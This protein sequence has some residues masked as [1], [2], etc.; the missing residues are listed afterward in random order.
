[1][2]GAGARRP[3]RV[4]ASIALEIVVKRASGN[5]VSRA[6]ASEGA[7]MGGLGS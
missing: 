6:T 1:V 3:A 7:T 2:K 4:T 5:V